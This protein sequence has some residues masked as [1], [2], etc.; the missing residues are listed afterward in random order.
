MVLISGHCEKITRLLDYCFTSVLQDMHLHFSFAIQ[1]WFDDI[2]KL[3]FIILVG[4]YQF[5]TDV[6]IKNKADFLFFKFFYYIFSSF[7]IQMSSPFLVSSLKVPYILPSALLPNPTTPASW[8]WHS[9]VTGH[10]IF[11]GPRSSPPVDDRLG[12]PLLHMQLVRST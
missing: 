11:A 3:E 1:M 4:D 9:P 6:K 7:T 2:L 12:H 10:I 5:C 8:P